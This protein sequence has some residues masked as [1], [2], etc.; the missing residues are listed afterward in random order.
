MGWQKPLAIA[1]GNMV[2]PYAGALELAGQK[3]LV[4]TV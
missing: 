4:Y 2:Q 1:A 3:A